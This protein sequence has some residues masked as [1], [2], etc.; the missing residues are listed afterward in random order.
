MDSTPDFTFVDTYHDT[1]QQAEAALQDGGYEVDPYELRG[2]SQ[3]LLYHPERSQH[4]H[5][6]EKTIEYQYENTLSRFLGETP[7]DVYHELVDR[8]ESDDHPVIGTIPFEE[9]IRRDGKELGASIAV[10]YRLGE[11]TDYFEINDDIVAS[12]CK[13]T[14]EYRKYIEGIADTLVR[15]G[16]A[17][18][19]PMA[20]N[21]DVLINLQLPETP[22]PDAAEKSP[23]YA[24]D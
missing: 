21:E 11:T 14:A 16:H 23:L 17:I 18:K 5:D 20:D 24:D 4:D 19:I 1:L 9:R 10:D 13:D 3:D 12:A 2:H 7:E 6:P 22:V 8:V 15:A